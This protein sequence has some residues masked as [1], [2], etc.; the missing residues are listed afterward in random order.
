[1]DVWRDVDSGRVPD[2]INVIVEIPKG[3]QNKYE[4]DKKN[5]IMKL[6]RVLF[7]PMHYPGD[8]GII[9]KTLARDNDPLDALVLISYPTFPG[10]LIEARPVGMLKMIDSGKEDDKILCVPVNDVRFSN[11]KDIKDIEKPILNEISHFF[12]AY[13]KLEGKKV[14][15]AGWYNAKEAKKIILEAIKT[16][17][18]QKKP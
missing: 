8:Y 16:F 7:S 18:S 3:S 13:K 6:D 2:Q 10:I 15:I 5:R 14:K 1:M 11:I 17:V 9:P 4:Y 12:E